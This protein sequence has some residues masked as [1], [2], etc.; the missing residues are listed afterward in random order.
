MN[1]PKKTTIGW[2]PQPPVDPNTQLPA[3]LQ[4]PYPQPQYQQPQPQPQYQ[5][6]QY[7]QPQYQQQ[8]Q[9]PY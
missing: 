5:Q 3:Y 1:E 9:F 4:Q 2:A 8:P 6:P 7:Q